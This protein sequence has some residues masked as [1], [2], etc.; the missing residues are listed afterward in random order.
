MA[1]AEKVSR[2]GFFSDRALASGAG[3][4]GTG[5]GLRFA[6]GPAP[7]LS[8]WLVTLVLV[9]VTLWLYWP[10]G[11][12]GY[13]AYDDPDYVTGNPAVQ[14]GLSWSGAR[15]AFTSGHASNWHPLTW[16]SHMADVSL[17]GPGPAG[18]HRMNAM[19]HAAN[20][21]LLFWVLRELCGKAAAGRSAWVAALFALHPLHVESVAWV[22]ERKDLLS[23]G[24]FLLTLGAYARYA[25]RSAGGER[26][27]AAGRRAWYGAALG[28]FA[29]GL[30]SKPMLVTLPCVLLLLDHWPLRRLPP[31]S[32]TEF[33]AGMGPLLREK[34]P[35]FMLSLASCVITFAVQQRGGS[36]RSLE[37]FTLAERLG[38]AA[39][40]YALYLRNAV[41]PAE[42]A[43]FYPHPGH[44]P[45]ARVLGA[46]ALLA[47]ASL[48]AWRAARIQPFVTTG[49]FWFAGM[50]VP[51]IGLVQVGNQALA[52]R[53]TYLPL[54]GLFVVLAWGGAAFVERGRWPRFGPAAVAFLPLIL[55]AG[56]S[57]AQLAHWR[58]SEALFRH[59]LEVTKN[60][61]VVHNNL[62]ALLF[63]RG[64]VEAALGHYQDALA[65][66]PDY[67]DA[68][69][70][71]G[72]ALL[73][74][75]RA[76]EALAHYRQAVALRPDDP[77]AH[78]NLGNALLQK[79]RLPE[80]MASYRAALNLDPGHAKA[81]H[82]LGLCLLETGALEAGIAQLRQALAARPDYANAR[83]N[84]AQALILAGRA[85]EAQRLLGGSLK[86]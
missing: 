15:W 56:A 33:R 72:N 23:A 60:N 16:L 38:N 13:V 78:L 85:D 40:A 28:S 71:L 22:S 3:A 19:L 67:A 66:Y 43:V 75:G 57:R 17:F 79:Q 7:V 84:L 77:D 49:W 52:D 59:A 80:A 58:D 37:S 41:W 26:E 5:R 65:A 6:S 1:T 55:C 39:V 25:Q 63:D 9:A 35:F 54:I 20:A 27:G 47:A 2:A 44:L 21:A 30:M 36:V 11:N 83:Q 24:F 76:D 8:P 61:Y 82:N 86:P 69:G 46:A 10:A 4:A 70:N 14:A 48:I 53:Y 34:I 18:P 45:P 68:H 64:Q 51:V 32:W 50:L 31:G 42:L 12:F 73:S 81:H 29:L 62:G 74:L